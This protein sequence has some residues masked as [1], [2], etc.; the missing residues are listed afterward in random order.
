[1][2]HLRPGR[3]GVPVAA[4]NSAAPG[5]PAA[6][7][8]HRPRARRAATSVTTLPARGDRARGAERLGQRLGPTDTGLIEPG[9]TGC[10]NGHV[11]IKSANLAL[12]DLYKKW[13]YFVE[14]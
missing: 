1:M 12:K 9:M 13:I 6:V 5:D 11:A 10:V 2:W 8:C 7:L 3:G 14:K 4:K